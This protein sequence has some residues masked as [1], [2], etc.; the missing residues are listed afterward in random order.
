MMKTHSAQTNKFLVPSPSLDPWNT[1]AA[2][3]HADCLAKPWEAMA[4]ANGEM[5]A[6]G[7]LGGAKKLV[8]SRAPFSLGQG[9]RRAMGSSCSL[10]TF[11]S[12]SHPRNAPAKEGH[13]RLS[14]VVSRSLRFH[15]ER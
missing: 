10:S 13:R 11:L 2:E 5:R 15:R 14:I 7:D 9:A 8:S 3:C 1:Q 4:S 6:L 12:R